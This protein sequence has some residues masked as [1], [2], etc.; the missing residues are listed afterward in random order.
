MTHEADRQMT[1]EERTQAFFRRPTQTVVADLAE[2][3]YERNVKEEYWQEGSAKLIQINTPDGLRTFRITAAE[4]CPEASAT[5]IWRGKRANEIREL[6]TAAT[7]T[8][9]SRAGEMT[10]IKTQGADNI[11]LR[12]LEDMQTGERFKNAKQVTR[13][14]GLNVGGINHLMLVSETLLRLETR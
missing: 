10:F 4:A 14:L 6:P 13:A 3:V 9:Q 7:V 8:Y 2:R 12:A 11:A 5:A 1:P